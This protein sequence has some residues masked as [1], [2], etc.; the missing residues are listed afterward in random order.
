MWGE[1]PQKL[2]YVNGDIKACLMP[3]LYRADIACDTRDGHQ[4][5]DL[6]DV[7][8]DAVPAQTMRI[9]RVAFVDGSPFTSKADSILMLRTLQAQWMH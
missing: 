6:D 7:V 9:T 1:G 2:V 5:M 3:C 4:L 8:G